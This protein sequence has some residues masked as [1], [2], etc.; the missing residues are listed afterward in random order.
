M[1]WTLDAAVDLGVTLVE[2]FAWLL[3]QRV[4]WMDQVPNSLVRAV[5]KLL[6]MEMNSARPAA[7]VLQF[8]S[9][10]VQYVPSMTSMRLGRQTSLI[11]TTDQAVTVLPVSRVA[12][13]VADQDAT[14]QPEQGRAVR[15]FP[16]DGAPPRS[17]FCCGCHI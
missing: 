15:M 12:L 14:V 13:F 2:L 11:F 5:L 6:R 3:E 17:R 8:R 9:K 16:C 4:Y 1:K 10:S 7:T